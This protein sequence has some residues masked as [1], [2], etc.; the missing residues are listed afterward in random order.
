MDSCIPIPIPE[1]ELA[2][3]VKKAK[4]FALMHGK[5]NYNSVRG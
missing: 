3:L 5:D 4:D 1:E 2:D